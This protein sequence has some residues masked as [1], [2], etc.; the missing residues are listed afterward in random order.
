MPGEEELRQEAGRTSGWWEVGRKWT[1]EED[2]RKWQDRL[3]VVGGSPCPV[4]QRPHPGVCG[5]DLT[6]K[7]NR[8]EGETKQG[9][10]EGNIAMP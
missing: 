4:C 6:N 5:C 10:K 8:E 1:V 3:G 9:W 2:D 7:K